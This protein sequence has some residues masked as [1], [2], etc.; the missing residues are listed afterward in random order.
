LVSALI[1]AYLE[2]SKQA[3]EGLASLRLKVSATGLPETVE[4][5]FCDALK[6]FSVMFGIE[7]GPD[8]C[9]CAV[10]PQR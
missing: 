9:N 6:R 2:K 5:G 10:I 8:L 3:I 4:Y 7:G 1:G